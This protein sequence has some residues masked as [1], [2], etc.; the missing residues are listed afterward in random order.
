[1]EKSRQKKWSFFFPVGGVVWSRC[2]RRVESNLSLSAAQVKAL[3]LVLEKTS[4][5]RRRYDTS[6]QDGQ[7]TEVLLTVVSEETGK[8]RLMEDF[9][10]NPIQKAREDENESLSLVAK[11]LLLMTPLQSRTFA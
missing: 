2:S 5:V 4:Q 1:M 7:K 3:E 10:R 6:S 9:V 11:V 8:L